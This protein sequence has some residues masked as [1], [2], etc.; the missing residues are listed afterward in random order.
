M[1]LN[2]KIHHVFSDINGV[3][4]TNAEERMVVNHKGKWNA[5]K[6]VYTLPSGK[7]IPMAG[8]E[9][10]LE[11]R[12]QILSLGSDP[13]QRRVAKVAGDEGLGSTSEEGLEVSDSG[14]A[15]PYGST[16]IFDSEERVLGWGRNQ[17][18]SHTFKP[19]EVI[20]VLKKTPFPADLKKRHQK[21]FTYMDVLVGSKL[22][23]LHTG[24]IAEYFSR[25]D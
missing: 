25:V 16:W 7:T 5:S 8:E 14:I 18:F 11:A 1:E 15:I 2:L 9:G 17:S 23:E 20:T 12:N 13:R 22:V 24:A 19:G 6:T 4:L 3:S 10:R 21:T